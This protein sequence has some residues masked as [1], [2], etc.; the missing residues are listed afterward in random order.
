VWGSAIA[1]AE[2]VGS[3]GPRDRQTP[4]RCERLSKRPI[5]CDSVQPIS[6]NPTHLDPV[7]MVQMGWTWSN[8]KIVCS[9]VQSCA[10]RTARSSEG[11]D[12]DDDDSSRRPNNAEG[13]KRD[14][15]PVTLA[16][17]A[18]RA[19]T[20][21]PTRGAS[22]LGIHARGGGGDVNGEEGR[23]QGSKALQRYRPRVTLGFIRREQAPG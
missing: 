8:P 13:K 17:I 22:G 11:H 20:F 15:R 21:A 18:P 23:G 2:S 7:D 5:H 1:P 14:A 3:R 12:D 4:S 9:R 19:G 6:T 16:Q 10:G